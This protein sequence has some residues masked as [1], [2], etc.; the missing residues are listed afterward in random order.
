MGKTGSMLART[1]ILA[2]SGRRSHDRD[3][4]A[5]RGLPAEASR[6]RTGVSRDDKPR[7]RRACGQGRAMSYRIHK[8]SWKSRW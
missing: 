1:E 4:P 2:G 6:Q 3:D 8:V 7:A 5:P